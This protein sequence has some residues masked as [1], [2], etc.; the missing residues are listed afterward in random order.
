[1]EHVISEVPEKAD[2][3]MEAMFH[4][5]FEEAKDLS[6]P[7]ELLSV[8]RLIGLETASGS[9][10]EEI[11]QPTSKAYLDVVMSKVHESQGQ[12]RVRG[13]PFFIIE[14]RD[15]GRPTAFSGAQVI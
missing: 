14:P 1:M 6:R 12:L 11:V 10:L 4:A 2:A 13:V 9:E 15:G 8:A 5:Y 7:E 3:L